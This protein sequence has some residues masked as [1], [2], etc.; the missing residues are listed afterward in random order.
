MCK[1]NSIIRFVLQGFIIKY[2]STL[3]WSL[4]RVYPKSTLSWLE[5]NEVFSFK[6]ITGSDNQISSE[7]TLEAP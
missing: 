5:M 2:F 3:I 1:N 6:L 4:N 7:M